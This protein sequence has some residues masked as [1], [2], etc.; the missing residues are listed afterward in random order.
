MTDEE[1]NIEAITNGQGRKY[2]TVMKDT[3]RVTRSWIFRVTRGFPRRCGIK[4][5]GMQSSAAPRQGAKT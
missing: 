1:G 3:I 5:M 2:N 4:V